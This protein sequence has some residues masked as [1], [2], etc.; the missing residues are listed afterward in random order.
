VFFFIATASGTGKTEC[1]VKSGE[2]GFIQV[3]DDGMLVFPEYDGG[4]LQHY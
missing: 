1:S 3:L 4:T 2:P